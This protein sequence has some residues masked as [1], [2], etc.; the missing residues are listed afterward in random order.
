MWDRREKPVVRLAFTILSLAA[1]SQAGCTAGYTSGYTK[2]DGKWC[3]VHANAAV[4]REVREIEADSDTFEVLSDREY[5]KD[6][7][8]VFRYGRPLKGI[9]GASYRL[10]S[11]SHWA[12][13]RNGVYYED[14]RVPGA[15]PI[16]FEAIGRTYG[17]DRS[18]VYC[19]TLKMDGVDPKKFKELSASQEGMETTSFAYSADDLTKRFGDAFKDAP[20]DRDNPAVWSEGTGT[21]GVS[22]YSGPVRSLAVK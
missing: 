16:T 12:V 4:G 19:G 13:D 22:T 5:A 20:C 1:M 6:K 8:H 17:R 14:H 3:Y 21:D 10:L 11:S 2:V 9:D 18:A 7:N 15:D